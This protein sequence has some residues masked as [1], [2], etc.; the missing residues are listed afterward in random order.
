MNAFG[1]K[2]EG[3]KNQF[4]KFDGKGTFT[5]PNGNYYEGQFKNGE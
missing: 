2:Y 1:S 3:E 5:Y 4:G